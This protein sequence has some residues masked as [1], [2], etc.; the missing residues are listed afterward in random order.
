MAAMKKPAISSGGIDDRRSPQIEILQHQDARARKAV[1]QASELLGIG[2]LALT[3][4][5]GTPWKVSSMRMRMA[6]SPSSPTVASMKRLASSRAGEQNR[7][8]STTGMA[9]SPWRCSA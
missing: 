9:S 3:Q 7:R 5:M 4:S 8:L 1:A 6:G 2:G